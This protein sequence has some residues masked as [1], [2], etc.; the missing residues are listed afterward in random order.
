MS[1][2]FVWEEVV[3]K[4]EW[5]TYRGRP[6][7]GHIIVDGGMLS[8]FPIRLVA[9]MDDEVREIMGETDPHAAGNLGL[10]IDEAI[11][12]PNAPDT[13]KTP[14]P[15]TRLRTVQRISRIVDTMTGAS[16]NELVRRFDSDICRLPAKGY[17]TLEFGMAG[18]RLDM[19]LAAARAAMELHLGKAAKAATPQ[20]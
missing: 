18:E 8:N 9:T 15:I 17:G 6:K 19:Y 1:I 14:L 2:P 11:A 3:W 20:P 13:A 7:Q 12:V 10:M 4:A 5:G 16:D